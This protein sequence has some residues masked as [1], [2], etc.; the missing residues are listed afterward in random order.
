[1]KEWHDLFVATCGSAAALTGLIFVG[2]SINLTRILSIPK[3]PERAL[4]SLVLLLSILI[5]SIIF[6]IPAQS[7]WLTGAEALATGMI[8]WFFVI[9][10]DTLI[11]KNRENRYKNLY[12]AHIFFNQL[13]VLPFIISGLL[14]LNGVEKGIYWDAVGIIFCF[15]KAIWDAWVL[16]VEINR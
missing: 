14:L 6:L 11:Y 2:V 10:I 13:A 4:L 12:L 7:L 9:R 5:R 1:M 15:I 8:T 3:L 16:L